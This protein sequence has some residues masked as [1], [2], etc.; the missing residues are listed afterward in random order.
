MENS[1]TA[2]VSCQEMLHRIAPRITSDNTWLTISAINTTTWENSWV[3]VV[4]RL[5][6]RPARNW[7]K[8]DISWPITASKAST[9][10]SDMTMPVTRPS[11]RRRSQLTPQINRAISSESST[12][13]TSA[14]V[15]GSSPSRL[16]PWATISGWTAVMIASSTMVTNVHPMRRRS[17][18]KYV[19]TRRTSSRSV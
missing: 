19:A 11:S 16:I 10:R 5:M 2:T 14:E 13:A 8:N 7:S 17:R 1:S 4:M 9:R 12:R 3:S 6:M 18:P 15:A